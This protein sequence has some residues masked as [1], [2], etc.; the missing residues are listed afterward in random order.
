MLVALWDAHVK[1]TG[2]AVCGSS[3]RSQTREVTSDMKVTDT[4]GAISN[5]C[6][7]GKVTQYLKFSTELTECK[8]KLNS[9]DMTFHIQHNA[10]T[11]EKLL[12][13]DIIRYSSYHL[14]TYTE[15]RLS[16]V[17]STFCNGRKIWKWHGKSQALPI[18]TTMKCGTGQFYI[19]WD[20]VW[21]NVA[22]V[23]YM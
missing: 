9:C 5:Y 6:F 22:T 18:D 3:S 4:L 7:N 1:E 21:R 8:Q 13:S 20:V 17:I 14:M 12:K 11:Y 19:H 16:H 23:V 10:T 15:L 2:K